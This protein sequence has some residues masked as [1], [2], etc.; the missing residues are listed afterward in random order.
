MP[1]S[2]RC[3]PPDG[4][5]EDVMSEEAWRNVSSPQ[6]EKCRIYDVDYSGAF[7]ELSLLTFTLQLPSS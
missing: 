5:A 1:V 2:F 7:R 6:G 3:A 4:L